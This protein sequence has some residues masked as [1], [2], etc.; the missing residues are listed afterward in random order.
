MRGLSPRSPR[1]KSGGSGLAGPRHWICG[2]SAPA[3]PRDGSAGPI[4]APLERADDP[5][6]HRTRHALPP[7][8]LPLAIAG[9]GLACDLVGESLQLLVVPAAPAAMPLAV[10]LTA[11]AANGLYAVAGVLLTLR[12]TLTGARAAWT[13]AVWAAGAGVSA[14]AVIGAVGALAVASALLF[15]VFCPWCIAMERWLRR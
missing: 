14:A 5:I 2:D 11:G 10:L 9:V 4:P 6:R 12:T 8:A 1:E 7:P 15:L 3:A 13:W